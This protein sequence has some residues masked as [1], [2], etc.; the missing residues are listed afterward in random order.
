M[1]VYQNSRGDKAL[2]VGDTLVLPSGRKVPFSEVTGWVQVDEDPSLEKNNVKSICLDVALELENP[3][4]ETSLIRI[5][6]PY[7]RLH[8]DVPTRE[9]S[10]GS[11]VALFSKEV[12]NLVLHL[13]LIV[14]CDEKQE[15]SREIL[16][17]M[18]E[19]VLV[20]GY[21]PDTTRRKLEA[22]K[23]QVLRWGYIHDVLELRIEGHH[24]RRGIYSSGHAIDRFLLHHPA[25][26]P[27]DLLLSLA[28]G[29]QETYETIRA[30]TGRNG[31]KGGHSRLEPGSSYVLSP[32]YQGCFVLAHDEPERDVIVTYL[33]FPPEVELFFRS[34]YE[35]AE[36]SSKMGQEKA[37]PPSQ[38]REEKS[39]GPNQ[40]VLEQHRRQ[41]F[42]NLEERYRGWASNPPPPPP[43]P[44]E[45]VESNPLPSSSG[46]I[47]SK[48]MLSSSPSLQDSVA[49]WADSLHFDTGD[50]KGV[51]GTYKG[52]VLFCCSACGFE[53]VED[54][55]NAGSVQDI[56]DVFMSKISSPPTVSNRNRFYSFRRYLVEVLGLENPK[57]LRWGS[58]RS[59]ELEHDKLPPSGPP[60]SEKSSPSES[61]LSP[62]PP[63]SGDLD[64]KLQQAQARLEQAKN[65]LAQLQQEVE[66]LENL[67]RSQALW[68]EHAS[69]LL[70]LTPHHDSS[71]SDSNPS[72]GSELS[73]PR[74]VLLRAQKERVLPGSV[75]L[76]IVV[77]LPVGVGDKST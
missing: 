49:K 54:I 65:I 53:S 42:Q 52:S 36:A 20:K 29:K 21:V 10:P 58:S 25:S 38:L 51:R 48:E 63:S 11:P 22:A 19:D 46:M 24:G 5:V 74:C 57:S 33:R 34:H 31:A 17:I 67:R 39:S 69:V 70:L 26:S 32:D 40:R 8:Q 73:C 45:N 15:C 47:M 61:K 2:R 56:L 43:P 75:S 71:C 1:E 13:N 68:V 9:P 7:R 12:E 27:E 30:V 76:R 18:R 23:N 28:A 35:K 14:S 6:C 50:E 72:D 37:P 59:G 41:Y 77:V 62:S 3:P 60:S 4:R 16:E 44:S 66:G 64:Q 55:K